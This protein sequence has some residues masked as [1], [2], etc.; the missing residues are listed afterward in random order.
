MS[1]VREIATATMSRKD[2]AMPSWNDV[3]ECLLQLVQDVSALLP[4]AME[5]ESV[6]KSQFSNF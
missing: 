5:G 2:I 3:S 4:V 1:I 6:M